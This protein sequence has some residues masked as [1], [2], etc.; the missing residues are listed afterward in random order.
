MHHNMRYIQVVVLLGF[1]VIFGA[2]TDFAQEFLPSPPAD[3]ALIYVLDDQTSS[4]R[5]H[6]SKGKRHCIQMR[7]QKVPK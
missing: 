1:L 4:C 5:Y 7:W 2:R 3:R 6:S